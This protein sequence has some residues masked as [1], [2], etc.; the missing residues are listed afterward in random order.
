MWANGSFETSFAENLGA[1]NSSL[2]VL[3]EAKSTTLLL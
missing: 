2:N 3:H 1:K